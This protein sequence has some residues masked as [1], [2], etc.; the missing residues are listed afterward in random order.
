MNTYVILK[1]RVVG[2]TRRGLR[3]RRPEEQERLSEGTRK[4]FRHPTRG[5]GYS[6]GVES[7]KDPWYVCLGSAG[8]RPKIHNDVGG[9][10]PCDLPPS[11]HTHVRDVHVRGVCVYVCVSVVFVC[12]VVWYGTSVVCML[13]CMCDVLGMCMLCVWCA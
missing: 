11:G 13:W 2:G 10:T 12:G 1:N 9:R 3:E 8:P 7:R 6:D 5:V 4:P